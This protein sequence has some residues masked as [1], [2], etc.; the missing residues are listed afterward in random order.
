MTYQHFH[1]INCVDLLILSL[2]E[3]CLRQTLRLL[4]NQ[5]ILAA[6]YQLSSFL[7]EGNVL[8]T[9]SLNLG[10]PFSSIKSE[11]RKRKIELFF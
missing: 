2:H 9:L 7:H 3:L 5:K 4:K 8:A 1:G 10:I 11:D 6:L